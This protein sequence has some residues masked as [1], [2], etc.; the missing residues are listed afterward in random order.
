MQIHPTTVLYLIT[1]GEDVNTGVSAFVG[2]NVVAVRMFLRVAR[3]SSAAPDPSSRAVGKSREAHASQVETVGRPDD[4]HR[5]AVGQAQDLDSRAVKFA[6]IEALLSDCMRRD[7]G[8]VCVR[9][10]VW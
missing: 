9:R 10:G 3:P 6:H 7:D 8:D 5:L 2:G 1:D 4:V